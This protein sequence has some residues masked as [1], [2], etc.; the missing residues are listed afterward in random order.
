[1]N[2]NFRDVEHNLCIV[3][4]SQILKMLQSENENE[5]NAV[6]CYGYID[7]QAG[8]TF[9]VLCFASYVNGDYTIVREEKQ[10]A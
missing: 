7:K 10:S 1:M 2:I 5:S 8:L 4:D 6:I 3:L 9:E